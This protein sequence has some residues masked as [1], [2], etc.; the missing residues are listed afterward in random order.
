M[1]SQRA[2]P[3]DIA[4]QTLVHPNPVRNWADRGL[5]ECVKDFQGRRWFPDES[6]TVRQVNELLGLASATNDNASE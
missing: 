5:L 6:K 1:K 3:K 2:T 4:E